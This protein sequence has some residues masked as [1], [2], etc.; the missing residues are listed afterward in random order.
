MERP[1]HEGKVMTQLSAEDYAK[2]AEEARAK[3]EDMV[4][5]EARAA[6]YAVAASYDVLAAEARRRKE[7]NPPADNDPV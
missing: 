1:R 6:M 4:N 5:D 7:H 3:A 2:K